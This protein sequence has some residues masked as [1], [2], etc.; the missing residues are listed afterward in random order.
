MVMTNLD[1]Q[2]AGLYGLTYSCSLRSRAR[3]LKAL[4]QIPAAVQQ[5]IQLASIP[6]FQ[7]AIFYTMDLEINPGAQMKVTGKVHS[8]A[9][10]Y[11]APRVGLEFADSVASVIP[12]LTV[13]RAQR[14]DICEVAFA[15][16]SLPR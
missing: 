7:F 16:N 14:V 11:C 9:N 15:L 12:R 3:P 5:D 2:F 10:L 8:N 4:Y 6:V 1:S 13:V